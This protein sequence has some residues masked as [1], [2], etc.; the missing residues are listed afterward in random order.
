MYKCDRCGAKVA[1]AYDIT[2]WF[3]GEQFIQTVCEDC[4]KKIG[5]EEEPDDNKSRSS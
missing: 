5:H 2:R 3:N 4:I 1:D